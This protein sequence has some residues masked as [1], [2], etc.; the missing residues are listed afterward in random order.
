MPASANRLHD[1]ASLYLRQH[2]ENPVHWQ[3]WGD[4]AQ[5]EAQERDC[6]IL[7]SIGYAACHWCHVME[8]ESFADPRCA[9]AMNRDFVCIK[10]DREERPDVDSVY[11]L[12]TLALNDGRGGWPMTVFLAPDGAALLCRHLLPACAAPRQPELHAGA[13]GHRRRLAP[14]PPRGPRPG[15]PAD[16]HPARQ[17]AQGNGGRARHH[18]DAG[19][20]SQPGPARWLGPGPRR[21][22]HGRP[23]APARRRCRRLR[24][25]AQVSAPHRL[26]A[27]PWA[28]RAAATCWTTP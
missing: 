16:R 23:A 20:D 24:G 12:A 21:R 7:L 28:S 25:G 1:A 22:R 26:G 10:V 13:G 9:E 4:A 19:R 14:A 5:A 18:S 11:M 27:A 15:G 6:P 17:P 2:G 3:P 8:E